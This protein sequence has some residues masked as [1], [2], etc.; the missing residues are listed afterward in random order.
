MS[1]PTDRVPAGRPTIEQVLNENERLRLDLERAERER[2][3]LRREVERLRG[4]LEAARRAGFRQAAPFSKGVRAAHPRRPGRR[5]GSAH[6]R[7]GQRPAPTLIND[8]QDV[9]VPPACP[10]CGGAVDDTHVTAQYQED[11]PPVRPVVRRFDVH[12]GRCRRC[13][14]RLQGR[15]PLQTSDAVGAAAVQLGP[16]ALA[17][18]ASFN[19]QLGLSFSKIETVFADRFGLTVTRGA[20]VRAVHRV[21]AK[22]Q[23]T[24]TALCETVKTSAMVVADETGWRVHA[25]LH[26]LWVF[27][28]PDTTVYAILPGRGFEEA[29]SVL[30]ADFGGI[31]IRDGWAP[32]RQFTE[33]LHQTC[34]AHLLRRSRELHQD[35]PHARIP[36]DVHDLLQRA[37]AV[38][39]RY[40]AGTI[41]EHGVAVVRGQ[42]EQQL[43]RVL[44]RTTVVPD[45][46][47]FVAHLDR[48][49]GALFGFL[50]VPAVDATNWRA[51]QALRPAVITRKVN[52]GGNRTTQ[53]A[54][55]QQ[56]L[57]SVL[58][59]ARQRELD[60]IEVLATLLRAPHPIVSPDLFSRAPPC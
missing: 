10:Q 34:V 19:K 13:G 1:N 33:A 28:T 32:Y 59:T 20:L 2:D 5:S 36:G 27:T 22:A 51:E 25:A 24:Y 50:R 7:H 8:V 57:A 26:W 53:G 40:A 39:D 46:Q 4:Q 49:W 35:H 31:L 44:D 38:R 14:R 55:T 6:G 45:V 23:P 58:R 60:G 37:L 3:R 48:E 30:G 12:I 11:L 43:A 16:Q 41:S 17:V 56:V 54:A 21:A 9:P 29:A 42:L 47:R 15:H 18:A 52:G